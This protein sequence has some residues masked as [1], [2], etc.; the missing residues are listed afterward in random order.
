MLS[1]HSPPKALPSYWLITLLL[2]F[3]IGVIWYF[4][5]H[6]ILIITI[7]VIPIG[8]YYSFNHPFFY[9]VTVY[10]IFIFSIT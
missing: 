1:D 6:P 8:A 7:G 9:C 4:L 2:S 10:F 5:P 3:I